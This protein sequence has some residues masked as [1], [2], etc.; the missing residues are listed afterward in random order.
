MFTAL[1]L[2]H[3]RFAT[4]EFL[5]VPECERPC[6]L[7]A[8]LWLGCKVADEP[9]QLRDILSEAGVS[10]EAS[11]VAANPSRATVAER[12]AEIECGVLDAAGFEALDC[13]NG[14]AEA[15]LGR[16]SECLCVQCLAEL[17]VLEAFSLA[18]CATLGDCFL[19][20]FCVEVDPDVLA[21]AVVHLNL[22]SEEAEAAA[23]AATATTTHATSARLFPNSSTL[24]FYRA[25]FRGF[26]RRKFKE[27]GGG[28]GEVMS[29]A[30]KV[31]WH[32][33]EFVDTG[34]AA[35]LPSLGEYLSNG[36]GVCDCAV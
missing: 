14:C 32:L 12:V 3:R 34:F 2:F 30:A 35:V 26:L 15:F 23:T 18:C 19:F 9:R 17:R 20:P 24:A 28:C 31:A 7:A 10:S 25:N 8:V 29:V 22:A 36:P 27:S 13:W 33:A 16:V 5:A 1:S 4:A 21:W 6:V 11:S